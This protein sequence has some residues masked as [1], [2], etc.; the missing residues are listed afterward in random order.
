MNQRQLGPIVGATLLCSNINK[1]SHAYRSGL[2]YSLVSSGILDAAQIECWNTPKLVNSNTQV[3]ASADGQAWLRLVEDPKSKA[4]KPLKTQGWM[5]LETNVG[6]VDEL[7]KDIDTTQFEIIGEPAYLQV[8]DAIKAMQTI[9]PANEVS[10]MTQV[11]RPVPPF[12]LPMTTAKT[13]GLF[14]PVLCTPDRDASL[15]FYQDINQTKEG[16]KFETKVTVLNRAWQKDIAH[17]YKV[18][19]L[20]L[21][22]KCLFE[23]DQVPQAQVIINNSGSLPSGIAMVTCLVDNIDDVAKRFTIPVVTTDNEY[24]PGKKIILL[25]GIAGEWIE[26]VGH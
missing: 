13:S 26:L 24:Y 14:I 25:K 18:A 6:D 2:G 19:T 1:V 11:D 21:N 8:S 12:E 5:A 22:G 23:I 17:Q 10:Y 4:H 7:R 9:G 15:A 20:Q 3:L 16:L